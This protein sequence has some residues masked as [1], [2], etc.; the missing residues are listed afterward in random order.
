MLADHVV[1]T[2]ARSSRSL[3]RLSGGLLLCAAILLPGAAAAQEIVGHVYASRS[4]EAVQGA[5]VRV[6]GLDVVAV[7]NQAGLFRIDDVSPGEHTVRVRY[8]GMESRELEV[9][10]G[11]DET[12]NLSVGLQVDVIPMPE[13]YATVSSAIPV[14]KLYE[15]YKRKQTSPGH[16]ITREE[17]AKHPGARPTD[18]LRQVPGLDIG[19]SRYGNAS[20]TM[21]RRDDCIPLYFVDG[22]RAPGFNINNLQMNDIAGIEVYRGHAEI[23]LQFSVRAR[24][25]VIV[26]WTRD[27]SNA[28]SFQ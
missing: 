18:V 6:E 20:V 4:G 28:S 10:L 1:P 23:P 25:G 12:A 16:F 8:L 24:C 22:A 13:I 9:S 7:T 19:P 14:N 2:A 3:L 21:G 26:L 17:I 15:F 27:P 5:E 11:F